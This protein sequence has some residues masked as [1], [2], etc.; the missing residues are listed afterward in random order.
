VGRL[1][2]GA[3]KTHKRQLIQTLLYKLT[4]EI[5]FENF[6]LGEALD[7]REGPSK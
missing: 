4:V 5:I 3:G 1:A 2:A 7:A 6:C